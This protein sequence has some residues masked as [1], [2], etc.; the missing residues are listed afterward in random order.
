MNITGPNPLVPRKILLLLGVLVLMIGTPASA[1]EDNSATAEASVPAEVTLRP[2]DVLEVD[3]WRESDLSGSFTVDENG[4]VVLPMLGEFPVADIPLGELRERLRAA[5]EV[6]LRNPSIAITPLRRIHVLGHVRNPGVYRVD[7]TISLSGALAAA[8]GAQNNA[9]LSRIR[10]VR[11]GSIVRSDARSEAS[12]A[13]VDVRSGDE[14]YVDER[15]LV[16]WRRN[17]GLVTSIIG[18]LLVIFNV[19]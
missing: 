2:G 12:L 8:G 4:F 5:Y 3:I 14:I 16:E 6:E 1:Q 15:R 19:F 18:G 17:L 13:E 10:I 11:Q 9:D 7:P